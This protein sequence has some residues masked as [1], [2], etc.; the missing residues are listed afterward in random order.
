VSRWQAVG[1]GLRRRKLTRTEKLWVAAGALVTI[2]LLVLGSVTFHTQHEQ[3]NQGEVLRTTVCG[4]VL[5]NVSEKEAA[6]IDKLCHRT[7]AQRVVLARRAQQAA[8]RARAA[9]RRAQD[10][11]IRAAILR[12]RVGPL[13]SKGRPGRSGAS[14]RNG[15]NG[16]NGA[17]GT[18]GPQGP[19]GRQGAP[20]VSMDLRPV[21]DAL[22]HEV[23]SLQAEVQQLRALLCRI[24]PRTCP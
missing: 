11:A 2:V 1:H 15:V 20:G 3:R 12:D 8:R 24:V 21:V 4:Q 23:D 9:A 6:H 22:Q 5:T 17:Q 16:V 18:R 13:T 14:G 19:P 10:A 7:R